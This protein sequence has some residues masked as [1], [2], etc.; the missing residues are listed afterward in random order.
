MLTLF[1][2]KVFENVI[3]L[4]ILRYYR[5]YPRLSGWA[6]NAIVLLGGGRYRVDTQKEEGNRK[7]ER[8]NAGLK[9]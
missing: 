2:E 5:S 6:L 8:R 1:E 9:D 4:R 7:R 3:A